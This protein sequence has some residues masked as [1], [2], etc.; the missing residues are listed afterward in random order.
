MSNTVPYEVIAAAPIAIYVAPV[1]T[2][3]PDLDDDEG[4]FNVAWVKLGSNG[5]LNYDD[6]G[7]VAIDFPQS[8]TKWRALGESGSRKIFRTEEDCMVKVKVVDLTLEQLKYALNGNSVTT[9]AAGSGTKGYKKIGLSRGL[10]V[11]TYAVLIRLLV[12]PYGADWIGQYEFPRAA[13]T[14][15]PSTVYKKSE[16]AGL[17]LQWDALVD[18]TASSEDERF[19][20]LIFQHANAS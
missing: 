12:S 7:G 4:D 9:V 16:P 13:Q 10:E 6:G 5:D 8:T 11:A 20:R 14:G 1:G 19:G 2:A 15:S 18:P 3:F 17:E